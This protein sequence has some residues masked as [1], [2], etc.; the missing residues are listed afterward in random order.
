MAI[1][2]SNINPAMIRVFING[3]VQRAGALSIPKHTSLYE[4]IL[5]AGGQP[6]F[7][8]N[9]EFIRFNQE[10]AMQKSVFNYDESSSKG[11]KFNPILQ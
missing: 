2:K 9:I 7:N 11:G 5:A 6:S 1:N 3:N 4:A 10:G 8:G